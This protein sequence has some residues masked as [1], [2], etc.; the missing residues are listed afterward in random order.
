ML[1]FKL[2]AVR[3]WRWWWKILVAAAASVTHRR[4]L[5]FLAVLYFDLA[6]T[7]I[8]QALSRTSWFLPRLSHSFLLFS[9]L[10]LQPPNSPAVPLSNFLTQPAV[11]SLSL[12]R[13]SVL[14][15]P[16][17]KTPVVS[18]SSLRLLRRLP[19]P[20]ELSPFFLT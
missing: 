18:L 4:D 17:F 15:L 14:S 8:P 12:F 6:W 10:A 11:K 3:V 19:K 7:E 20:L 2:F 16:L 9:P 1:S 13:H 5:R